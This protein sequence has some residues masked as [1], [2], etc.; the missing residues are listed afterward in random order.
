M[1]R[2]REMIEAKRAGG[3]PRPK[4]APCAN[5]HAAMT[6]EQCVEVFGFKDVRAVDAFGLNVEMT[7]EHMV[8]K[9]ITDKPTMIKYID[10][11]FDTVMEK[12]FAGLMIGAKIT[13]HAWTR[14]GGLNYD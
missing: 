9:E 13:E 10:E 5:L 3:P 2:I 8:N 6:P 4:P 11:Y 14:A 12:I 7:I 1:S